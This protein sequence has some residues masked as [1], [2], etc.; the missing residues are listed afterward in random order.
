MHT[1]LSNSYRHL[2]ARLVD[3]IISHISVVRFLSPY[4]IWFELSVTDRKIFI[5]WFELRDKRA[6]MSTALAGAEEA[7]KKK[8]SVRLRRD[9]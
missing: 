5:H 4:I 9:T 1:S 7:S 3:R 6:G 8:K 2:D